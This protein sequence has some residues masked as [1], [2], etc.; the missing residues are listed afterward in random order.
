M[1]TTVMELSAMAAAAIIGFRKPRSPRMNF[2]PEGTG[3]LRKAKYR[4]PA[5]TG[6]RITL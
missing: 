1:V 4:T 3:L 5:A 6:M 2:K